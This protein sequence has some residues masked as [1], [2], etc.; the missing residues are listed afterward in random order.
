MPVNCDPNTLVQAASCF[1]CIP[2]NMQPA[3]QTYLLLQI[4]GLSLTPAQLLTAAKCMVCLDGS[5]EAAQ[6]YLLCQIANQ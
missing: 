4:S 6:N 5:Q 1:D 3:V 2:A